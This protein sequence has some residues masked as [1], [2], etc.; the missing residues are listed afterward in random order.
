MPTLYTIEIPLAAGDLVPENNRRSVVVAPPGR[1]RR[2][3]F[4]QGAPGFEHTFLQRALALDPGLDVDAVVRKGRDEQEQDV[5]L[6]Q[7]SPER[8]AALT[9][10]YPRTR[11]GL[12]AYDSVVLAN[13]DRSVFSR[14]QLQM[15]ADFVASRGGGL[16]VLGTRAFEPGA[17]AGTPLDAVLPVEPGGTRTALTRTSNTPGGD[18]DGGTFKPG[19]TPAGRQHPIMKLA[20]SVDENARKWAVMPSLSGRANPGPARAGA[21]VL[22][23]TTDAKGAVRPLVAVESYGRGRSMIFAGEASWRWKMLL[24]SAD[25]SYDVFWRQAIRWIAGGAPDP[26]SI[27]PIENVQVGDVAGLSIS[28]AD[29]GFRP[30]SDAAV[31][32]EVAGPTGEAQ[33]LKAT[34]ANG[35]GGR[36]TVPVSF[37]RSGIYRLSA[38]ALR[39]ATELG[40][41]A[42]VVAA[43]AAD[44]EFTDPRLARHTLERLSEATGGRYL[45]ADDITNLPDLL[46]RSIAAQADAS[47]RDLWHEPAVFIALLGLLAAEWVLRRRW[48][49]R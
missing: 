25:P 8:S 9:S 31:V 10:G 19:L 20:E 1:R 24:P 32:V 5:F 41:G 26:V 30:V 4:V 46:A 47:E 21:A 16:L 3:L 6:V 43:G 29:A 40:S 37:A 15:T 14:E 42:Q 23:T 39:G 12:F 44:S 33:V 28:V 11:E 17:L 27:A 34:L 49:L 13:V 38:Q 48:G 22:A 2:V 18:L 35:A 36:Y 7:G 45:S